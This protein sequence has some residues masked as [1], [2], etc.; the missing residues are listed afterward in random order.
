MTYLNPR[1]ITINRKL[2]KRIFS[3][4]RV[5]VIHSYNSIPC[6]EWTAAKSKKG[7][8]EF[9]TMFSD[10]IIRTHSAHR[11][12]YEIF[13]STIPSEL[14]CDHLCRVR[15][16]VNPAH[17]EPVTPRENFLRGQSP[18]AINARKTH[19]IRGHELLGNNL[20]PTRRAERT[21]RICFNQGERDR[22]KRLTSEQLKRKRAGERRRRTEKR[23]R[24]KLHKLNINS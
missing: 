17:M 24:Q 3:K 14:E 18:S 4:I 19:C 5:S 21:C 2:L 7:Y 23:M 8:A 20:M 1:P 22:Y 9:Y 10:G 16:C 11:S 6:W 15:H 13:V 12:I